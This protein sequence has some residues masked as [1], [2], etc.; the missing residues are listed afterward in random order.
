MV[1]LSAGTGTLINYLGTVGTATPISVA[2]C[3]CPAYSLATAFDEFDEGQ[4][5]LSRWLVGELRNTFLL[6]NEAVLVAQ[7]GRDAYDRV[8]VFVWHGVRKAR[9]T[10]HL[11]YR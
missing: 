6:P 11:S 2:M 9:R 4:P 5:F 3:C 8:C 7:H 1:G 10:L